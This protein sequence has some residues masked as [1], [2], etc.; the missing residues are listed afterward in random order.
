MKLLLTHL[1]SR[2]V[3]LLTIG[4]GVQVAPLPNTSV[5][6]VVLTPDGHGTITQWGACE[7]LVVDEVEGGNKHSI[8]VGDLSGGE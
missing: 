4:K 8:I 1:S 3:G 2:P 5:T 7:H 6:T